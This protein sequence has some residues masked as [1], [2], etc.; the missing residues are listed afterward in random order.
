[1]KRIITQMSLLAAV[2]ILATGCAP[3]RHNLPPEQHLMEPGPGVGGPGPGIMGPPMYG[4]AP[5]AAPQ[6]GSLAKSDS[7][8]SNKEPIAAAAKPASSGV[9]QASYTSCGPDCPSCG[10]SGCFG[11]P[12]VGGNIPAGGGVLPMGPMAMGGRGTP[13]TAQVT[14]GR[15]EGMQ[16]RYDQSGSGLFDSEPLIVPA[17]QNFPQGGLYRVKLTNVPGRE[18]V[19]LYPTIELAYANPRTGAY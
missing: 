8:S 19:E 2:A 15:P 6:G 5:M 7:A 13:T 12:G 17:R 9:M 1:M 16:V 4:A 3:T 10:G 18:G 14:F 11:G